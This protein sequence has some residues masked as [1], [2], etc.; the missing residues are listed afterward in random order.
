MPVYQ[1]MSIKQQ[2]QTWA[3]DGSKVPPWVRTGVIGE[4]GANGTLMISTPLGP[5]RVHANDIVIRHGSGMWARSPSEMADFIEALKKETE[6]ALTAI[7]VG[8]VARFGH[9]S[10]RKVYARKQTFRPPIGAMPSI[11]W[12]HTAE[13]TVDPTYQRSIENV[14]S[15][16][17]ITSIAANF[18]W[19]LCAPLV[20]SR[21]ADGSK[22]IIDGQHRWAAALKRG[23]LL[24]LPCCLFTYDSAEEEAKMF[25]HA[26][27]ARKPMNRLD[28]F[29]AA[30]VAQDEDTLEVVRLVEEAGLKIARNPMVGTWLPG[31]IAFVSSIA[32]ALRRYG[33]LVVSGALTN[34]AEAF[35]G[36]K[37][38][39]GTPIF[40]ALSKILSEPPDS[41]DPDSLIPA[42]QTRTMDEWR[43]SI[44]GLIGNEPRTAVVQ[45]EL[46]RLI[47]GLETKSAAA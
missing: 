21:R 10:R 38:T 8:K 18:D 29:F 1:Q 35:Q 24:H 43:A 13:L 30:I 23:D 9:K 33:P 42:L 7:G 25:I 40:L 41:F 16:R 27:R 5:T 47:I 14:V 36:Q 3:N 2:M 26:N 6:P 17:L 19:R 4:R 12:V 11:E 44:R 28:D 46:L 31:E 45:N 20:V 32:D 37:L 39:C 34:L 15:Q 22:V